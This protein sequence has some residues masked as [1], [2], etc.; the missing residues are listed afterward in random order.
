MR[1]S[2]NWLNEFVD[3]RDIELDTLINR[4]TM[5]G[6]EVEGVERKE[7]V[8][9]V[10]T[11]KVLSK[12]KHPDA[13][14]LSVCVVD[15]GKATYQVVCGAAN[16]AEGQVVPF[17]MV[18]A[19]LPNGLKIK[20]TKIRG[21][22]SKGM[23]C[24]ASELGLEEESDGILVLDESTNVG[25]DFNEIVQT[26][27]TILEL[28]VTPNRADC[29]SIL[30][31]AREVAT[32]FNK[33]VIRKSVSILQSEDVA[34]KYR[35][36]K[37]LND[38]DCPIYLGR[39]IKNI[40][41]KSS[42]IWVQYRLRSAGIRPINNIVDVTNYL[43]IE[44]GQPL[45]AFD[46][47]MIEGGIV[48]RNASQGEKVI[49]LDGKERVLNSDMLVIADEKKVLAIAGVMGGEFSGISD[50]TVDVFLECAYFRP[51]SIRMTARRLGMKTDS[52]YRYERGIDRVQT[53]EM[54]DKAAN[55]IIEL[56]GGAILTGILSNP[57]KPYEQV[58][59][60][61]DYKK[62]IDFIGV[63]L[64]KEE[65]DKILTSAGF[66]LVGD[67]V[68]VPSYRHDVERWQDLAEEVARIYGYDK[69]PV[70]IPKIYAVSDEEDNLQK[71]IREIK[72]LMAD[73]G[74]HEVINYSFMSA[75]IVDRY[76]E[77]CRTVK[78]KNPIS[79]DMDTMRCQVFPGIIK[80]LINNYKSGVKQLKV[81]EVA[82]VHSWK[83][84][85]NLPEERARLAFGVMG[86]FYGNN[87]VGRE[88]ADTFFYLKSTL[89]NVLKKLN[90]QCEYR[91]T[92]IDFLHP[93][94]GADLYL[95]GVKV[96]F[97]G[98][99]HPSEYERLDVDTALYICEIDL[100]ILSDANAKIRK[101]YSKI[102]QYPFIYRDIAVVL[103]K[104]LYAGKILEFIKAYNELIKDVE[105]F[106]RYEGEKIGDGKVSLAFRIYLNHQ[107]KTLTD[108]EANVIVEALLKDLSN[109]FG[110]LLR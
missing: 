76:A 90:L 95:S 17:A 4:L 47:K 83:D 14:K 12:S 9:N 27:D 71:V 13:D 88:E 75:D 23:I 93:G 56:A 39:I 34:D 99:L 62:I 43:M 97:I 45:H 61:Y 38:K 33:K 49:T 18:G 21:V 2:L 22:E 87:W 57:Y 53:L 29:L 89:E 50:D 68:V 69:I 41:V 84:G 48:V 1:V 94:K 86:G 100:N 31:V 91:R 26:G 109:R 80:S 16:V 5:S 106:D 101:K 10:I 107:E 55:M 46:L 70:T 8:T 59:L 15:T 85:L 96:G 7:R 60:R 54:I 73:I 32:L 19:V 3:I 77:G 37:V 44:Y 35:Y 102:T 51:E 52:S 63:D 36:V 82:N 104:E 40:E 72:F 6:L 24:S 81:F 20:E 42:P 25:V 28:N 58:K 67:E 64:N 11:A 79:S 98:E 66:E 30:G 105:L 92:E 74:Y 110:A 65:V 108:E 78:V 103:D